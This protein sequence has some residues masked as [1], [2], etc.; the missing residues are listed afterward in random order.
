MQTL[1]SLVSTWSLRTSSSIYRTTLD[2]G[3]DSGQVRAWLLEEL[4]CTVTETAKLSA[5]VL[6]GGESI[7]QEFV[8]FLLHIFL[9][10]NRSSFVRG[11]TEAV[12]PTGLTSWETPWGREVSMWGML[13]VDC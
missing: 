9:P 12:S 10:H 5:D 4:L 7:T 11:L 6:R 13:S 3:S 2:L 1:A 8:S